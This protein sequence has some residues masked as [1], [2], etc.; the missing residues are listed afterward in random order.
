MINR[1]LS[2]K[3]PLI[4]YNPLKI[5]SRDY[6]RSLH[7]AGA[8]PVIDTEFFQ[9]K[10]ILNILK[11]LQTQKIIFGLRIMLKNIELIELLNKNNIANIDLIILA[12]FEKDE[13]NNIPLNNSFYKTFIEVTDIEINNQLNS[14]APHAL[15]LKGNEA[16]GLVSGYTSM[17]LLQWYIENSTFPVFIHGGVGLH[18]AA[19][20]FA[21]GA[22][23]IVLD[24]QLYLTDE[25]P[26]S[27]NFK[28]QISALDEKDTIVLGDL[29][30]KRFRV[31]SKLGTEITKKIKDHE[32]EVVLDNKENHI[33]KNICENITALNDATATPSQSL[34]YLGQDALFAKHLISESSKVKDVIFRLFK[35]IGEC[36]EAVD[37]FDPMTADTPL[38]KEHNTTY[39]IIQGPMANISDKTEFANK[40]YE[41]GALPFLALGI[42]PDE[43]VEKLVSDGKQNLKHFGVGMMGGAKWEVFSKHSAIVKKYKPDYAILAAAV[44][45]QV[46]GLEDAGIKTYLHTPT[47]QLIKSAISNK[48][49]RFIL[50]GTEA[51]GHVGNLTSLVLWEMGIQTL[52]EQEPAE[53]K[54]QTLIFAGGVSSKTGSSFISGIA[55]ILSKKQF[56]IGV[57]VATSYLYT[58]EAINTGALKSMYQNLIIEHK[59]TS[60]IGHSLG[61]PTRTLK[62]PFSIKILENELKRIREKKS[63]EERRK[64]FESENQNGLLIAAKSFYPIKKE[65][66]FEYKHCDEDEHFERGNYMIGDSLALFDT[67]RSIKDIHDKLFNSKENL[68]QNLNQLE[69]FS[70]EN[71]QIHDEIAVV[72]IGGIFPDAPNT[73]I[74]WQNILSKKYS[75]IKTPDDRYDS[76]LYHD[77]DRNAED[78]SYSNIAGIIKDFEFDYTK[79]G[80]TE[81]ESVGM[82][83]SQKLML[84]AAFM[85]AKDS[86]YLENK[87]PKDRT[88][89][90]TAD[91]ISQEFNDRHFKYF[92]PEIKRYLSEIN[93]FSALDDESKNKIVK[94]IESVVSYNHIDDKLE[95][96]LTSITA[97]RLARFLGIEGENFSTDAACAS[98][99]IAMDCAIKKLLSGEYD[100]AVTGGAN[101]NLKQEI[102]LGFAKMGGLSDVGSFPFDERSNGFVLG[103]GAGILILKRAKDAIRDKDKIYGIIKSV[104]T[105]SDGKGK[106]IAA[107]N[108]EGQALAIRRSFEK[109]N[110]TFHDVDYIEAH[111]TSTLA[112]DAAEIETLKKVY[113][114]E[115]PIGI[116]S[117]K[118]QI[119]HLMGGAGAA[120]IIK[121]L[122]SLKNKTLPPNG[123]FNKI[124]PR[125][126]LKPP[127][128]IITEPKEWTVINGKTRKAAISAFGFGGINTHILVEEYALN[129]KLIKREI[130]NNPAYDFNDDRI[131]IA[132]MGCILPD[133]MNTEDFWNNLLSNKISMYDIPENRI[134]LDSYTNEKDTIFYIPKVKAGVIRDFKFNQMKYKLPPNAV[135]SLDRHQLF[136]LEAASQAVESSGIQTK[137]QHGNRIGVIIGNTM[138]GENIYENSSRA[139]LPLILKGINDT[140]GIDITTKQ[141]L[142][143]QIT[144]QIHAR[145][146]KTNEDTFPGYIS[147]LISGRIAN[148]FNCNGANFIVDSASVSSATAMSMAILSLKNKDLEFVITGGSDSN[149]TPS[150]L[151][152]FK[153]WG[154][155]TDSDTRTFDKNA[156]GVNLGEGASLFILTRYK[157]AKKNNLPILAELKN[158]AFSGS[159]NEKFMAPDQ[160]AY[161]NSI[162]KVYSGNALNQK[163]IK[164]V[165]VNGISNVLFDLMEHQVLNKVYNQP[166][167]WGN[168]K[169]HIGYLKSANPSTV[170]LKMVLMQQ[171][172]MILPNFVGNTESTIVDE[173]SILKSNTQSVKLSSDENRFFAAN[174]FGIGGNHGHTI[175]G[176]LPLWMTNNNTETKK[177]EI[178]ET[179]T[180][181]IRQTYSKKKTA[182]LLSGQGA[183]YVGMMRELYVSDDIIR[184]TLDKGEEIFKNL[185]GYSILD[186]MFGDEKNLIQTDNTQPAIFLCSASLFNYFKNAGFQPDYFAGHS[187]GEF[188]ALYCSGILNF[189][190]AF[191]LV[192][193]RAELMKQCAAKNPGSM[194]A[195]FKDDASVLQLINDSGIKNIYLANKNSRNQTIVSGGNAELIPFSHYLKENNITF[196]KI[197]VVTAFHSPFFNEAVIELKKY[198]DNIHFDSSHFNSVFSNVTG[199][200]Y[201][202][203]ATAV[204]NLLAEQMISPVEFV[205]MIKNASDN[206]VT[207]FIEFGPG[208]I[209]CNLV[210]DINV[211]T[212]LVQNS[213]DK[214]SSEI[215]TVTS[216]VSHLKQLNLINIYNEQPSNVENITHSKDSLIE[217]ENLQSEKINPVISEKRD[218][219]EN[220]NV[221]IKSF[222]NTKEKEETTVP[223][224]FVPTYTKNEFDEFLHKK[225]DYI[226]ELLLNEFSKY[227]T[228][229][230]KK[231]FNKFGFYTGDIV[232]SG[233]SVGLPGTYRKVFDEDNFDAII[234]GM[235]LIE[236]VPMRE[237]EKMVD[238]NII[239]L[240]KRSDGS[241]SYKEIKNSDEVIQLAARLGYFNIK[242]YGINHDYGSVYNLAIAAGFEALKDAKIP[243]VIKY[244]ETT[245]GTQMEDGYALPKEMQDRTGVVFSSVFTGIDSIAEEITH[246]YKDKFLRQPYEEFE[247]VYFFLMEKVQNEE[248][249]KAVSDWY[250]TMREK[251]KDIKPYQFKKNLLI[252]IANIGS[253][254]FA[255][256]IQAK[257]SN[258]HVSA[259]CAS[260]THA[261][262]IAED[263]I[264]TNHCDRVIVIG[265]EDAASD[266]QFEWIGSTFLSMGIGTTKGLVNEAATPFDERRKGTIVGSG[267]VAVILEK[268]DE[269]KKRGL[270]GQAKVLGTYIRNSAFHPSRMNAGDISLEMKRFINRIETLY[271]LERNIYT[272]EMLFMSHETYTPARGGSATSEVNALRLTFPEHYKFIT[273]TNTKGYSGHT[274]GAGIEDAIMIKAMQKG[275]APAIANLKVIPE[276][277]ADLKFS[278]GES[279]K[280][281]Y[282]L[283]FAAGF[284]SH[285]S[286][287]FTKR[288][289]EASIENNTIYKNWLR[290]ISGMQVPELEIK[291]NILCIIPTKRTAKTPERTPIP[292]KKEIKPVPVEVQI[293]K[294]EFKSNTNDVKPLEVQKPNGEV[295]KEIKAIIAEQTGYSVDV[296]ETDLDLEADLGIDTVK[297]VDIFGKISAKF[298]LEVPEDLKLSEYNTI[299][300]L[301][302][303][304]KEKIYASQVKQN[305][306]I[307][308]IVAAQPKQEKI[309]VKQTINSENVIREIKNIIAEQTGYGIDVLEDNLDLEADLGID[310]VKQVD[311]FGKISAK[312]NL[313]VPEDL[314]LSE[315]STIEKLCNYLNSKINP[316]EEEVF[317]PK[318]EIQTESK[319]NV[320]QAIPENMLLDIKNIIAEQTGYGID[321]LEDNL[322]LEADLGIDTVKQVDIFGKISAK[323][324]LEV[325]EDLKLSEYSTIEKLSNYLYSKINPV[326]EEIIAPKTEIQTERKINVVQAIP[327]NMLLDIKNI[328]AEQTG[329]GIDVL[330]DN[331]DL[332]ADL[333]ID[334]VK[335]VDIFGKISAK[336]NLEVPE[337]LKLSEYN[338]IEKLSN[339]LHS[340]ILA[341]TEPVTETIS[342]KVETKNLSDN[343]IKRYVIKLKEAAIPTVYENIFQ[344]KTFLI[345]KDSMGL[346]EFLISKIKEFKGNVITIGT[347]KYS[348]YHSDL[349][350]LES[351]EI[352]ISQIV[353]E[354]SEINGFIH[355]APVDNYFKAEPLNADEINRTVK[356]FFIIVKSLYNQLNSNKNLIASI[357]FNSV[358]FPYAE[359]I[360]KIYP[361]FAGISGMMKSIKKEMK[362]TIVK[363]V[364]FGYV[365]L[366]KQMQKIIDTFVAE[367]MSVDQTVE[368]GYMNDKKYILSYEPEDIVKENN[369]IKKNSTIVVTGGARGITFE[370]IKSIATDLNLNLIILGRSDIQ[371]L[372]VE[373]IEN[374][375]DEKTLFPILKDSMNGAKPVEIKKAISRILKQKENYLNI[376]QLESLGV[377]VFY[378]SVDVA[379]LQSVT[380]ALNKYRNIDGVIHGA[381]IDESNYIY[382]KNI[383]SFNKVFDT[384][385]LGTINLINALKNKMYGF[386][387]A[388]SSVAAKNGNEGQSDYSAANDMM[389]KILLEQKNFNSDKIYKIIDWT[390][391]NET[392]M[393]YENDTIKKVLEEMGVEFLSVKKGIEFFKN[394]ICDRQTTETIITDI[395]KMLNG[396]SHHAKEPEPI[397]LSIDDLCF[398]DK[399]ISLDKTYCESEYTFS[400]ERDLFLSSHFWN[401]A[402]VVPATFAAEIMIQNSRQLAPEFTFTSL[403]DYNMHHVIKLVKNKNRTIKIISEIETTNND[404]MIVKARIVSDILNFKNEVFEK[405]K[406]HYDCKLT[407]SSKPIPALIPDNYK[408]INFSEYKNV[409]SFNIQASYRPD[410]MFLGPKMQT[411]V[412]ML[413]FSDNIAI[414]Q[415]KYVDMDI[416]NIPA[417][418]YEFNLDP[419]LTDAS[420]QLSLL[421]VGVVHSKTGLPAKIENLYLFKPMKK[422]E[423][424]NA[425]T[426]LKSR[427]PNNDKKYVYDVLVYNQNWELLMYVN[428]LNN[429]D[430]LSK[431]DES[432]LQGIT[433]EFIEA[434]MIKLEI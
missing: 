70:S 149:F 217:K 62:T 290:E 177:M 359:N 281:E 231:E 230:E 266:I 97:A 162:Q 252:D 50:E 434:K 293:P 427:E 10:E 78:K 46:S 362:N 91:C 196:T 298:N 273:I 348:D 161:L 399:N 116:S 224:N 74:F 357:S 286:M 166:I 330:E 233:V 234:S 212:E 109:S 424:L 418:K 410:F 101:S 85:A 160:K 407:F 320:V 329:Y 430:K 318:T 364:D 213:I 379:D 200:I 68:F 283:H 274:I 432:I 148:F 39:P 404:T 421:H 326:E 127:F 58:V 411:M 405:D 4:V 69:V 345:T 221:D 7:D 296:L 170:I 429:G 123:L 220:I 96:T 5:Y 238:K 260:A 310:T 417:D 390:A 12:Y 314:K 98:T 226:D 365:N 313:E 341:K 112:G 383:S 21:A 95:N 141:K 337:D 384:K 237:K 272:R 45:S 83:R 413:Y 106:A 423:I 332:E 132:G 295:T 65:N 189:E 56:K 77:P 76:T 131:V 297:Q 251:A 336:F 192:I 267:A 239:S 335:Q 232:V 377:K 279:Y 264:R 302:N 368:T 203:D 20:I 269:I 275:K 176:N 338:T 227:K 35:N 425:V 382:K 322:D 325:P 308:E 92:Y 288:I 114:T 216:L 137:F 349:S 387:I 190:D 395:N 393:A 15:I 24:D 422:N 372:P 258:I 431:L 291:N 117:V 181:G 236:S 41:N 186:I 6:V 71:N 311:I 331:L 250:F 88:I 158:I 44:P 373:Y 37:E 167:Y 54:K 381:G 150:V 138:T 105:S 317:A 316:V 2:S 346:T 1:I 185:K 303:Y 61:F 25:S 53:M 277:F 366:A 376:K 89:I 55:S 42:L 401:G 79:F 118:S 155:L 87:F 339:Y 241:A 110:I 414:G 17:I 284:G 32:L 408:N 111:G 120:G 351:V 248:S 321:V 113:E 125:I 157:T 18:T 209:L 23:G 128:Y 242:D 80:F 210:K 142:A 184:Q 228:E 262:G 280:Y 388:F 263:W 26:L 182:V 419:L 144:N 342:E 163:E 354:H 34:F 276:D 416:L 215:Q 198:L 292:E 270:N 400:L 309:S 398:I 391:W 347:D 151:R 343:N 271:N 254:I 175:I 129:Y 43:L 225:K 60:L 104:G 121:T 146:I 154:L 197:N 223:A 247:K 433:K 102:Y 301:S 305:K 36:L 244:K 16:P 3:L 394:E 133:A 312:F 156:H 304:L 204:K 202:G 9:P 352:L 147:N 361:P 172:K 164:Y 171:H 82:S 246:Y 135:K 261:I 370:I 93:E 14:F 47:V 188:T 130:F 324:N 72:G 168:I 268:E 57:S 29:T 243:L 173:N 115:H 94:Q 38:A 256:L 344:N 174:F 353:Q 145:S 378:E 66:G 206:G 99:F 426:I 28:K 402:A 134:H 397:K 49:S 282:G 334:T 27:D 122:L 259:A 385:V 229:N 253:S 306:P 369:F 319:I 211:K 159:S 124:S 299:E 86:G 73:E 235:N 139:R 30:S 63:L 205:K 356:S 371:K 187:L 208:K 153:A 257:G 323:F 355:F 294:Q 59:D 374:T 307:V 315:Y 90:V 201:S 169:H 420:L 255:Q 207:N 285:F 406:L 119:G 328:I 350:S 396:K 218:L 179:S 219:K 81:N 51:G 392:G 165:E 191:K 222:I 40:L 389:G 380:T 195:V 249:K 64:L 199:N 287:F 180:Q 415:V 67:P 126:G 245:T 84:E 75:I 52:L 33:Y 103:E 140:K 412:N 333:G 108:P 214:K 367:L 278:K 360:G 13:L 194:L 11:D 363:S 409:S 358:I 183:Q 428:N 100:Y 403:H 265:G 375:I 289:E 193:K 19:G 22:N 48:V 386:F 340:K 327:E 8:L 107:P 152:G 300:K 136:G 31:F 240:D 178:A 143:E